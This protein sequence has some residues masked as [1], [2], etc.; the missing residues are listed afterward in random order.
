MTA[1]IGNTSIDG[2]P[3]STADLAR[4]EAE[5]RLHAKQ[6]RAAV[7]VVASGSI[8]VEDCRM[9]LSM[10]GLSSETVAAARDAAPV[11]PGVKRPRKRRAA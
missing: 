10:L 1:R 5:E 3:I 6:Q 2:T 9:L 8:D 11:T 7:R 4:I